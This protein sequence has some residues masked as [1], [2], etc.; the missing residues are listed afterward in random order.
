MVTRRGAAGG[1][2]VQNSKVSTTA[3]KVTT[4]RG[5]AVKESISVTHL[6]WYVLLLVRGKSRRKHI[7]VRDVQEQ[8]HS[9]VVSPTHLHT[10]T[11]EQTPPPHEETTMRVVAGD[12]IYLY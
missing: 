1:V 10:L 5:L 4:S 12:A 8:W 11:P 7:S 3:D 6:L 2:E 9:V